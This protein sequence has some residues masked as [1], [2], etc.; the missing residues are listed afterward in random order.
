MSCELTNA[1][2]QSKGRGG[3]GR[4]G[5]GRGA[6]LRLKMYLDVYFCASWREV[7]C[8]EF[9]ELNKGM[10]HAWAQ[11]KR[12]V[13]LANRLNKSKEEVDAFQIELQEALEAAVTRCRHER[14]RKLAEAPQVDLSDET[15]LHAAR[16]TDNLPLADYTQILHLV[17]R[18][19]NVVS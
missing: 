8:S 17:P 3:E 9:R 5:A 11:L 14:K 4:E 10:E 16:F 18:L 12:N 15:M 13:S 1:P 2:L 6:S 7:G 19:V